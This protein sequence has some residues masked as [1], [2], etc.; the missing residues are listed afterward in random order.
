M[1]QNQFPGRASGSPGVRE[2]EL[3]QG[4]AAA[5][6]SQPER[7]MPRR[8]EQPSEGCRATYVQRVVLCWRYW[9]GAVSAQAHKRPA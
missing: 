2:R 4:I 8:V 9:V 1:G 5:L 7:I 3:S 6:A